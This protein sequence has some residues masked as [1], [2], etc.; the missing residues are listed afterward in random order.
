MARF[1]LFVFII[2]NQ[3]PTKKPQNMMSVTPFPEKSARNKSILSFL[4]ASTRNTA[5][6]KSRSLVESEA[7]LRLMVL[8]V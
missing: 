5:E 8:I 2:N 6:T 4:L 3:D 1:L 7:T